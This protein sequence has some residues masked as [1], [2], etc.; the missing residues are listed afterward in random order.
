ME[1][2]VAATGNL[3]KLGEIS[4]ILEPLGYTVISKKAAGSVQD[5][6][7]ENGESFEENAF[8]K[9]RALADELGVSVIA[10]DSGLEVDALNGRP[11]IYSARFAGDDEKNCEYLLSLMKTVPEPKRTARFVCAIVLIRPGYADIIVRG[12]CEGKIAFEPTGNAGFGY[13]PLFI[14]DEQQG[15]ELTF[16]ELGQEKKDAISHRAKALEAL[17]RVIAGTDPQSRF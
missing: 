12:V 7:E 6:P 11:G 17:T 8:I 14:P 2:L 16:A 4:S 13:D 10:D 15:T 9:A 3:H 1:V 5:D